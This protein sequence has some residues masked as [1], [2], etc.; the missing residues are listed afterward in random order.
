MLDTVLMRNFTAEA[1]WE[2]DA[3]SAETFRWEGI[4]M[5]MTIGIRS[6]TL[7]YRARHDDWITIH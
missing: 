1:L 4:N 7:L 6:R 3:S 5:G 2:L